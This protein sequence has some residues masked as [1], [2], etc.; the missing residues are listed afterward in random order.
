MNPPSTST[1]SGT[2]RYGCALIVMVLTGCAHEPTPLEQ[3]LGD[4]VREARAQQAI[5]ATDARA[6]GVPHITDGVIAVHGVDRFQ[7]SWISPPPPMT[8]LNIQA[9]GGTPSVQPAMPR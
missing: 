6:A 1:T 8:V 9:G 4:T 2:V 5:A 3:A 7:K